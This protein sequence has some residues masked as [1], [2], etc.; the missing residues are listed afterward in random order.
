MFTVVELAVGET[1]PIRRTVLRTGTVS[2]VVEFDGDELATTFHL[3]AQLDGIVVSIS[4]WM[5]RRYP[6]LPE[7]QGHQVRGMATTPEHRGAGA[8][9]VLLLAG[10]ERCR[11]AE[12]GVVWA[13]ARELAVPFYL[14]HGFEV[15]GEPYV[16]LT[17][18]LPHRDMT[19][20]LN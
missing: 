9:T 18:G 1:H 12:S 11:G 13:R 15:R 20:R 19:L 8:G 17:T 5:L 3:G 14:R 6:D 4:T 2:T 7:H 10:I 16:D